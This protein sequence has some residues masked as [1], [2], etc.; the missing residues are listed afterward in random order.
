MRFVVN[1]CCSGDGNFR[2]RANASAREV[3]AIMEIEDSATLEL[4]VKLPAS[5][6]L[7]PA[8]VECRNKVCCWGSL[9]NIWS[10]M[11]QL[12]S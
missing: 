6:P 2:V 3:T 9:S 5:S 7:R 4:L 8:E 10:R 12:G 11:L 1:G